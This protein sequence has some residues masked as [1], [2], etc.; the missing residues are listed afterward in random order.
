MYKKCI[1]IIYLISSK[2]LW[3]TIIT[4]IAILKKKFYKKITKY[5]KELNY[6]KIKYKKNANKV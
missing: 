4:R 1:L 2:K 3:I 5:T 6:K